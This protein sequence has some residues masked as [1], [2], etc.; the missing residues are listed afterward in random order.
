M[1]IIST[2]LV[3][4]FVLLK[5]GPDGQHSGT[6]LEYSPHLLKVKGLSPAVAAGTGKAKSTT[7]RPRKFEARIVDICVLSQMENASR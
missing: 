5:S 7:K 4:L 3:A 1:T 2:N 6:L